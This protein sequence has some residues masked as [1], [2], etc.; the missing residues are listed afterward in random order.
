MWRRLFARDRGIGAAPRRSGP[1]WLVFERWPQVIYAI[2][3]VHGRLDLLR[4]LERKI[5]DDAAIFDGD[6]W[7]ILLGDYVDRGPHSA[8][9]L[10]YLSTSPPVGF[11]RIC[12]AGNHELMMLE[13]LQR[14]GNMAVWLR[15]GGLETLL[16]Y[17]LPQRELTGLTAPSSRFWHLLESYLPPEHVTFLE[18]LPVGVEL[19]DCVFVHAGIRIGK[20]LA[21]QTAADV[22]LAPASFYDSARPHE[23]LI[24]HGHRIVAE[25]G[26]FGNRV[27]VDTGAYAT[28]RLSAARLLDRDRIE[29]L[30]EIGGGQSPDADGPDRE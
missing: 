13:F 12:I 7:I 25:A 8:Q 15:N 9:V 17:G 5:A 23:K 6:K 14:G 20:P 3:D 1:R 29:F 24:V 30:T 28:G 26:R 21:E 22:T 11:R 4:G 16:S 19:P 2:G 27:D 10:D 18:E